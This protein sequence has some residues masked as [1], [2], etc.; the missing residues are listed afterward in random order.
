MEQSR[1]DTKKVETS[2][3]WRRREDIASFAM[4]SFEPEVIALA[5][6]KQRE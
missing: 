6:D 2:F 3:S 5:V 4:R 1:E